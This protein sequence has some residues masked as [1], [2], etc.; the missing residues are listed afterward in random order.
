MAAADDEADTMRR[1]RRAVASAAAC[2]AQDTVATSEAA[3]ELQRM[4]QS[5][6]PIGQRNAGSSTRL[7]GTRPDKQPQSPCHGDKAGTM[8][9]SGVERCDRPQSSHKVDETMEEVRIDQDARAA[10]AAAFCAKVQD[11]PK[12]QAKR[13]YRES[14]WKVNDAKRGRT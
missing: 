14:L 1:L 8:H 11:D 6:R 9:F 4:R 10:K 12:Y 3:V 2:V 7:E 5:L 13:R